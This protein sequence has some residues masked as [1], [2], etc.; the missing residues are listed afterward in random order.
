[1]LLVV[2]RRYRDS[3]MVALEAAGV[4]PPRAFPVLALVTLLLALLVTWLVMQV[5][6]L[7]KGCIQR[8]ENA[9][10]EAGNFKALP[11]GRF[12]E[13]HEGRP[14]RFRRSFAR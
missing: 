7:T 5:L 2:G 9:Q 13:L 8:L 1:M 12:D 4:G 11:G 14:G 3:E 10:A 6:S